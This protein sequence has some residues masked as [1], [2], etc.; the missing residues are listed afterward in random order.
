MPRVVAERK[1]ID[2]MGPPILPAAGFYGARSRTDDQLIRGAERSPL[3]LPPIGS[4]ESIEE[5]RQRTA[6][7][8]RMQRERFIEVILPPIGLDSEARS[9]PPLSLARDT[10]PWCER[11]RD[12]SPGHDQL[13]A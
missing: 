10:G 2:S 11:D 9:D 4:A 3:G 5:W 7:P 12:G 1:A 13:D 8:I 6:V